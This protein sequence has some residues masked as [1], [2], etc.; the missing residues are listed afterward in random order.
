MIFFYDLLMALI[1]FFAFFT[2]GQQTT[3]AF[4][5]KQQIFNS[6][7][8]SAKCLHFS[9]RT[10]IPSEFKYS[11]KHASSSCNSKQFTKT[12]RQR[13]NVAVASFIINTRQFLSYNW[14]SLASLKQKPREAVK[15][16]FH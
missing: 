4:P 3:V 11:E 6:F 5:S 1:R 12:T 14:Q 13:K 16:V 15:P 8:C 2:S 10:Q 7:L 9:G